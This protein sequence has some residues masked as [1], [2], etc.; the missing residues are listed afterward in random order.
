[1]R[2]QLSASDSKVYRNWLFRMFGFYL[3]IVAILA[4]GVAWDLS[5]R[6][7]LSMQADAGP[8]TSAESAVRVSNAR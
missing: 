4:V 7:S 5:H 3:A 8:Q 6:G 1:M 2:P